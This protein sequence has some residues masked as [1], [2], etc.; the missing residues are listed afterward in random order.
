MMMVTVLLCTMQ[1]P[2]AVLLLL[3]AAAHGKI[4]ALQSP[5]I[6]VLRKGQQIRAEP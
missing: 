6:T 4:F 3:V 2:V 1:V 5:H